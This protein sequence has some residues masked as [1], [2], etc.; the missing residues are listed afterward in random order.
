V[1]ER[2]RAARQ[3]TTAVLASVA[4]T[5]V[6]FTLVAW[7]IGRSQYWPAVQRQF[8]SWEDIKASFPD[9]LRGFWLNM[10]IWLIAQVF[11]VVVALVL[12]VMRVLHGPLAAPFRV[13]AIVYIDALRGVPALLLILLFGFGVPALQLPGLPT[14]ALFWGSVAMVAG[15]AAYT[16]EVFR[17]GMDAVHESQRMAARALG[18]SQ[19]QTLRHAV[20]PQAVR[21]VLPA[22][23]NG[24]VS[25]Q[26]DVALLSVIGVRDAVREAQ[27]YTAR[28]YNYSSLI[29]AAVLFLLASVPLARFTDW[30]ATRDRK[31]R[32][33]GFS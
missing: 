3:R 31:R 32:T 5:V 1:T 25:L 21:N 11:I 29:G 27:I 22:L 8:F 17:S 10:R 2:R 23:L 19:W 15:Y 30:Y 14:G 18:L 4:S 16:A 26:K 6:V 24:S 12:A 9:V 13:F 20:L 33:Q 7:W 28:T